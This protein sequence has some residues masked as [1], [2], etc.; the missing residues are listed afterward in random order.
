M[1]LVDLLVIV[2]MV[3]WAALGLARG[4]TEQVLSLVGL[5][6]GALAGSRLAWLLPEGRESVWLPAVALGAALVLA[7]IAQALLLRLAW[8]LR[9]WVSDGPLRGADRGAGALIGAASGLLLAWLVAVALIYQPSTAAARLR[10]EVRD[11]AILGAT[12]RSLPPADVLGL[13][14]RID[15][16]PV[17][18]IPTPRCWPAPGRAG[19]PRAWSCSRGR[20]AGCWCRAA[21]GLRARGWWPRTPT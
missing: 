17:L 5:V 14:A 6:G 13:L 19:P 21:A 16:F 12:L 20:P 4:A 3:L 2:W 9:R 10:D 1:N 8:P 18:P 11:S 15:P 7:A